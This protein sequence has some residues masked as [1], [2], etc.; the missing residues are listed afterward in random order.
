[1][2]NRKCVIL[3]G[4]IIMMFAQ[5]KKDNNESSKP[6]CSIRL[7]NNLGNIY[8]YTFDSQGRVLTMNTD[9]D[10]HWNPDYAYT[11][12]KDSCILIA[13]R[14]NKLWKRTVA[15]LNASGLP[16]SSITAEFYYGINSPIPFPYPDSLRITYEY[17]TEGKLIKMTAIKD[18]M[19]AE[20]SSYTWSNGNL[21][22][23]SKGVNYNY[24]NDQP[25]QD[26][27][28][29]SFLQLWPPAVDGLP[30]LV[31]LKTKNLLKSAGGISTFEFRYEKNADGNIVVINDAI[32]I[33]YNCL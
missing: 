24:Y 32:V 12:T 11:Y 6:K 19:P 13:N 31:F 25:S 10:P 28:G 2:I 9:A 27:D 15:V 33:G 3:C 1:M 4:L 30:K 8:S 14:D 22:S 20:V 21:V 5:C 23:D 29:F 17:D 18:N 26:G 16:T 7:I